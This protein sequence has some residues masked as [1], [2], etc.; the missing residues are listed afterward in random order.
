[1][2]QRDMNLPDR[3]RAARAALSLGQ[4]D[5]ALQS[6]VS[7]SVYQKYELG[8]SKPGFD[9]LEGFVK[10]GVNPQWL[11][12]GEGE[13]LLPPAACREASAAFFG[14]K[15]A[16]AEMR[17]ASVEQTDFVAI[18]LFDVRAAAGGGSVID[19]ER[20]LDVLH[21]KEEWIRSELHAS[22]ADLYMIFVDGESME[23]TLRPGDV[24]LVDRRDQAQRRDG[25][26]V[27]RIDGTLLVKR[28]Q[29]LPGSVI[30]VTSD[31]RSY[32]PFVLKLEEMEGQDMAIIGRVV[33]VGRKV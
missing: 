4:K 18:P 10:A 17:L 13:M 33:W 24:I 8:T 23:P 9:A 22:P 1:M 28:L 32:E 29:K 7:H 19:S 31:N 2:S 27:L 21:F 3:L 15:P 20:I 26:Y 25:I 12:T 5:F 16:K 11:L 30:R 14:N 6:G